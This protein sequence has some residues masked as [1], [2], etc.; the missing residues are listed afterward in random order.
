MYYN[1]V[2]DNYYSLVEKGK[3]KIKE[4]QNSDEITID[5][6]SSK[7]DYDIGDIIGATDNNTGISIQKPILKKIIR[8]HKNNINIEYEVNENGG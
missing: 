2:T 7:Y 1:K 8:I 3:E 4:L 5:I 6:K